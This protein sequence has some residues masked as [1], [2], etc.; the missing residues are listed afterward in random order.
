MVW[1]MPNYA[2][3]WRAIF[4]E[5]AVPPRGCAQDHSLVPLGGGKVLDG[6]AHELG[7]RAH[8]ELRFDRRRELHD[9]AL[10]FDQGD[11]CHS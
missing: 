3:R 9:S 4:S 2:A 5:F 10:D 8:A 6:D 1:D 7:Q 11:A